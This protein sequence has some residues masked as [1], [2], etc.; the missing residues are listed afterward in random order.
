MTE[1]TAGAVAARIAAELEAFEPA[2]RKQALFSALRL[3]ERKAE[4]MQ[5]DAVRAKLWDGVR[6]ADAREIRLLAQV[7]LRYAGAD[8]NA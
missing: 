8:G 7:A 4:I 1:Q 3:I 5:A 6:A 2:E